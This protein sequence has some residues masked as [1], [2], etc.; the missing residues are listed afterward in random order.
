MNLIRNLSQNEEV[1]NKCKS[2]IRRCFLM[3]GEAFHAIREGNLWQQSGCKGFAEY[4]ENTHGMKKST[5]YSLIQVFEV[6]GKEIGDNPEYQNINYTRLI[7]IAPLATEENKTYL[8]HSAAQIPGAKAWDDTVRELRGKTPTD[9][10]NHEHIFQH[11]GIEQ[12]TVCGLRR[13][14]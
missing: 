6:F 8:L 7:E 10:T 4:I 5:A 9:D 14:C 13:K 1:I 12:C 3:I 2:N 11:I